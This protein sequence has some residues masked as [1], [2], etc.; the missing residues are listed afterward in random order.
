MMLAMY[1]GAPRAILLLLVG[2]AVLVAGLAGLVLLIVGLVKRRPALWVTGIVILAVGALMMV[3]AGVAAA[4]AFSHRAG[5]PSFVHQPPEVVEAARP[6]GGNYARNEGDHGTARAEG[7]DF[8]VLEPGG[9]GSRF[10]GRSTSG[11]G[12]SESRC[13]I[14]LGE[15]QIVVKT[16]DGRTR[17]S[18]N[19]TD[20]GSVG[21]GDSVVIDRERQVRVSGQ[22]REPA[23]E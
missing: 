15:V 16:V 5:G 11:G 19:G 4:V 23:R 2:G 6:G 7:V 8:E 14:T 20:Y 1:V 21:Q 9:G 22:R 18:V 17:F 12:G 3:L 10:V 13:E